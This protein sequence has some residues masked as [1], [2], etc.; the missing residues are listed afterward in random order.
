VLN[1]GMS[2]VQLKI[3][4][5]PGATLPSYQ[6]TNSAGMDLCAFLSKPLLLKPGEIALVST[7]LRA[8]LPE[9]YQ[10]EI[11][12]RSGLALK[13][14]IGLAN[15][16]G[17]IDADYRGDIGVILINQGS[18]DFIIQPGDRIA[19]AVVT[20]Y[21][22]VTWESVSELDDTERGAGGFG[23]TNR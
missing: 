19:Q 13:N 14:G 11:R 16:V 6:T 9:G 21:E 4:A 1:K 17:T 2:E 10:M 20:T 23:S 3:V 8:A 5:A 18:E 15:G 22:K 12:G 7:G